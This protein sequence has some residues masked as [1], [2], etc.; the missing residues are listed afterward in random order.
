MPAVPTSFNLPIEPLAKAIRAV[1]I[2]QAMTLGKQKIK[3]CYADNIILYLTNPKR[4]IPVVLGLITK[5]GTISAYQINLIKSNALLMNSPISDKLKTISPFTWAPN[6]FKYLGVNVS[7]K[8]KE[9][10]NINYVPLIQKIKEE[11]AHWKTLPISFLG[12]INVIKMNAR[13]SYSFQSLPCYLD[14][15]FF[16]LNL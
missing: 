5:F 14:K 11:L 1:R 12:R 13:F 6:G 7:P 8:L 3:F 4:S 9:L 16:F 15:A 2:L 10:H